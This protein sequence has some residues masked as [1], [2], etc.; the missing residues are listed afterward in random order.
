MARA[1][2]RC[3]SI[4][5]E[6]ETDPGAADRTARL[7]AALVDADAFG[8]PAHNL[9]RIETHISWI[10]LSGD[11]AYK[12]KKPVS[13]G[14]VD[15]SS[16]ERRRFYCEE[17][18]RLNRRFA[19]DV[20]LGLAPIYGS[21]AAPRL[22]GGGVAIEYAVKMRRFAQSDLLSAHAADGRLDA[23]LVDALAERI[24]DFHA[25][26][27]RAPADSEFGTPRSVGHWSA[28][29]LDQLERALPPGLQPAEFH[30]L[31]DWYLHQET[32]ARQIEARR[33]AGFVRECHGDLHLGNIALLDGRITPFDCIEFNPELR[34][35]D[36]ISET[37]FVAMDLE[38]RGHA[39]LGWRFVNRYLQRS[40][41]YAGVALLRYYFVYRALVRAK[42]EALRVRDSEGDPAARF[43]PALDYI[44]LACRRA[45]DTRPGLV[46]MHGLSGSGKS[47]VAAR[48]VESLGA[49]QLR[50]DVERKRLFGLEEGARSGSP[51]AG[52]IY[53]AAA[54]EAT[55][56]RLAELAQGLVDA[57]Y[58]VI[59]DAAFLRRNERERLLALESGGGLG[60]VIVHCDAPVEELRRRIAAR[61]DDPSEANLD[62]LAKQ[63][64]T[65]EPL[66]D[67]E[68]A[69]ARVIEIGAGGVEAAQVDAIREGLAS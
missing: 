13:F 23:A 21:V 59:V 9:E 42:V 34:W 19:P 62:V 22:H 6:H 48:L 31:E 15:F 65:V 5:T 61:R 60:R 12:I 68:R 38:A 30:R 45:G 36:T 10:V 18:L 11:Y 32:V 41:D 47:T 56:A 51:P 55:Y 44:E 43:R 40:G 4:A 35:I 26:C 50:S 14:F 52:G 28:E 57:G 49:I 46:L 3:S 64:E 25:D 27:E 37:A 1:A 16:L 67:S 63:L 53:T 17:E 29:N 54:G 33:E 39:A 69:R 20:Y 8:H 66:A 24:A 7:V 2:F 58:C